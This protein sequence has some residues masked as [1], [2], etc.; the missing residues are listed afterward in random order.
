MHKTLIIAAREFLTTLRRPGFIIATIGVPLLVAL[1]LFLSNQGQASDSLTGGNIGGVVAQQN[2][3]P[4]GYVDES[5]TIRTVPAAFPPGLARA[6][7]DH[8]AGQAALTTGAISALYVLPPDYRATGNVTEYMQGIMNSGVSTTQLFRLLLVSNLLPT[9]D[10]QQALRLEQPMQLQTVALHA[11]TSG[12]TAGDGADKNLSLATAFAAILTFGIFM[13]SGILLQALLDEKEN[14]VIEVILTSS[15]PRELLGG[16]VLGLGLLALVQLVVWLGLGRLLL[17]S[18]APMVGSLGDVNLPLATWVLTLVFFVLGYLFVAAIM[19]GIGAISPSMREASQYSIGV[20]FAAMIPLFLLGAL[21]SDPNG[22]LAIGLS[23]FPPT[24]AVTMV[25]RLAITAVPAW[26]IAGSL[27]LL[28]LAGAG[29]LLGAARLFRASTLLA[30]Q[31]LS[32]RKLRHALG[33]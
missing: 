23:L 29:M 24:A 25:T 15:T 3:K 17:G 6:Y 26:Q 9:P 10:V 16:K 18:N 27:A 8:A 11:A 4:F 19:A 14:R 22:G 30:G 2:I 13:A 5:N 33:S 20:S 31:R 12:T 28:A 7:P 1:M 21:A 32:L